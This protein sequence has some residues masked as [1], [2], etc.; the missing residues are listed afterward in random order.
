MYLKNFFVALL[1]V[2]LVGCGKPSITQEDYDNMVSE[3][4]QQI[5]DL[6]E[7]VTKLQE[8][9]SNLEVKTEEVNNQFKRFE[10]EN[11]RDVVPDAD[12]AVEELNTEVENNPDASY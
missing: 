2:G 1:L 10:N 7:Q 4:D 5:A 8:H 9:I 12:N 11:W 6:E 3:K